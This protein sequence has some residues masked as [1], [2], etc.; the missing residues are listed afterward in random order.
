MISSLFLSPE[1]LIEK[2]PSVQIYGW[3]DSR[4]GLFYSAHLLV[5]LSNT[6]GSPLLIHERSFLSLMSFGKKMAIR[7]AVYL[8]NPSDV[9]QDLLTP[10]EL[11]EEYPN[12][13]YLSWNPTKI[14]VLLS[15][16]LLIGHSHGKGHGSSITRKS[17]L[18]LV[19]HA[20]G[21]LDRRRNLSSY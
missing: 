14:G 4:I 2:Y 17:F 1:K 10:G 15:A 21:T 7:K 3:N 6:G 5:G 12:V 8:E 19:D 18:M 20:H 13:I 16:G 9:E 11:I